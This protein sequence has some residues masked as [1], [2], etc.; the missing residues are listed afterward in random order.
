MFN[1][2]VESVSNTFHPQVIAMAIETPVPSENA[3]ASGEGALACS[4]RSSCEA[5]F[6]CLFLTHQDRTCCHRKGDSRADALEAELV[7][8][9]LC[10]GALR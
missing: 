2:G 4:G 8:L 3:F 7:S 6:M 9:M 10:G 1:L 5:R